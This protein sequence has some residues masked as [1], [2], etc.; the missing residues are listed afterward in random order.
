MKEGECEE[1]CGGGQAGAGWGGGMKRQQ[2]SGSL[3][4]GWRIGTR[5]PF[6]SPTMIKIGRYEERGA[7]KSRVDKSPSKRFRIEN[8]KPVSFPADF[9]NARTQAHAPAPTAP[10]AH[11]KS[12]HLRIEGKGKGGLRC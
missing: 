3:G 10:I 1:D 11:T 6:Y 8:P 5:K 9:E 7:A 2:D 12:S 4:L